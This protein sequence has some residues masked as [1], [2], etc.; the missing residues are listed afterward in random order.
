MRKFLHLALVVFMASASWTTSWADDPL[1]FVSAFTKGEQGAI[2]ALAFDEKSESLKELTRTTDVENPF[3]LA[4]SPNNKFLYAVHAPSFAG[5]E[6]QVAS[7]KLE[8][9]SGSL[10]LLNRQHTAGRVTCYL[11]VDSKGK[12]LVAANYSTGNVVS[13]PIK[14]DGSLGKVVSNF[15]HEGSSVHPKRQQAPFAHCF[16][17]SPDNRFVLAADLGIDKVMSYQLD[18]QTA[19]LKANEPAFA[20]LNP[21]SGPRHLTFHPRGKYVYVINELSNTVTV[22]DYDVKQGALSKKQVI[23]TLPKDFEGTS[24]TADVKVTPDGKYLYGTNRGHDSIACYKIADDGKLELIGI[25]PSL[26]K[27]PQNLAVLPG[28]KHLLCANMPGNN[29]VVFKIDAA[30]GQIKPVGQPVEVPKASCIMVVK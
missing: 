23:S 20:K 5:K 24:Y 6:N 13:L 28:G 17:I 8:G 27:G 7:Y 29:V 21:G 10:K 12:A 16:V 14:A 11:D 25:E 4:L 18:S 3:F 1:I 15:Q 9:R 19:T 2:H 22:F 26:G 30:T